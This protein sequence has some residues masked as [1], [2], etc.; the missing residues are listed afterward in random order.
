MA[1]RSSAGVAEGPASIRWAPDTTD[2]PLDA[3]P[4]AVRTPP[5]VGTLALLLQTYQWCTCSNLRSAN[6][7]AIYS[8]YGPHSTRWSYTPCEGRGAHA[9]YVRCTQSPA[10]LLARPLLQHTRP[11]HAKKATRRRPRKGT[12]HEVGRKAGSCP[13]VIPP[14][15]F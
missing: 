14:S 15:F 11:A 3:G 12:E 8:E 4:R 10:P 7:T 6:P 9:E 13:V 5:A 1:G 2:Q